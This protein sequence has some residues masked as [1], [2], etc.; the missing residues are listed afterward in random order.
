[1]CSTNRHKVLTIFWISIIQI[2]AT[3]IVFLVSFFQRDNVTNIQGENLEPDPNKTT[4]SNFVIPSS[5]EHPVV[6]VKS[7]KERVRLTVKFIHQS[8]GPQFNHV[9]NVIVPILGLSAVKLD[10]V[11]I[12]EAYSVM[13][14]IS[15]CVTLILSVSSAYISFTSVESRLGFFLATVTG[16]LNVIG[17][18]F[19]TAL[20][21]S[22]LAL[23]VEAVGTH[24]R[25]L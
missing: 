6:I 8:Y 23:A 12:L 24:L 3:G 4:N 9:L 17:I 20:N 7:Q 1:V 19:V 14:V 15:L 10:S 18:L 11:K 25:N 13:I 2:I 21:I 22:V 5:E 16:L